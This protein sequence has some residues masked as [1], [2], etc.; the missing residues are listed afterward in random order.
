MSLSTAGDGAGKPR[1]RKSR[2]LAFPAPGGKQRAGVAGKNESPVMEQKSAVALSPVQ[3]IPDQRKTQDAR[4]RAYLMARAE[5]YLAAGER[6]G[7][8]DARF[9]G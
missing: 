7:G 3:G 8:A 6:E 1:F 4:M 2:H 5:T 9:R